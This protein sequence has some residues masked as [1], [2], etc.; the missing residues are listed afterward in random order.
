MDNISRESLREHV[1]KCRFYSYS[2][3]V[4]STVGRRLPLKSQ[5]VTRCD[6]FPR[7]RDMPDVQGPMGKQQGGQGAEG[8]RGNCGQEALLQFPRENQGT[9]GRLRVGQAESSQRALGV[10]VV[11][12]SPG[13]GPGSVGQVESSLEYEGLTKAKG[14]CTA[15]FVFEKCLHGESFTISRNWGTMGGGVPPRSERSQMSQRQIQKTKRYD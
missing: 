1:L 3:M 2:D 15:P 13:P 12:A 4:S 10:F 7:G 8:T 9:V 11:S 5:L 6:A 14:L